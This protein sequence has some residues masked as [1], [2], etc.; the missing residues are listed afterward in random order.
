MRRTCSALLLVHALERA[1]ERGSAQRHSIVCHIVVVVLSILQQNLGELR[2]SGI[3]G[4]SVC[5]LE[6]LT[7]HGLIG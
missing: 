1:D 3:A 6:V 4:V 5:G 7:E 2:C